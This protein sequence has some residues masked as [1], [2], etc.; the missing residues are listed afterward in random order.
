M[1]LVNV[2][3][4]KG[5]LWNMGYKDLLVH[6]HPEWI[7]MADWNDHQRNPDFARDQVVFQKTTLAVQNPDNRKKS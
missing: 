5:R 7:L 2:P 4:P 3:E 6:N 1:Y